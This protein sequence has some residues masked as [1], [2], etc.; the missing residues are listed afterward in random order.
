MPLSPL[1]EFEEAAIATAA[2]LA[3]DA[4]DGCRRVFQMAERGIGPAGPRACERAGVNDRVP[5]QP[6]FQESSCLLTTIEQWRWRRAR[7]RTCA[8][9]PER[10]ALRQRL[11]C[12]VHLPRY[13]LSISDI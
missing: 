12:A 13:N 1:V 2:A 4:G 11:R 5:F 3:D 7:L 10:A 9:A 6:V 8:P